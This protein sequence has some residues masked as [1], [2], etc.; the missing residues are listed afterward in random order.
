[1]L[2]RAYCLEAE[3]FP[4]INLSLIKQCINCVSTRDARGQKPKGDMSEDVEKFWKEKF[5]IAYPQKLEATGLS[6]LKAIAGATIVR[7]H[8]GRCEDAL[9]IQDGEVGGSAIV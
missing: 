5:S 2:L 3:S 4:E 1:M 8:F 6:M 7:M 9:H